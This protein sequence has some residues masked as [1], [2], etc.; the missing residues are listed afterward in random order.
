MQSFEVV[1]FV[2]EEASK[3]EEDDHVENDSGEKEGDKEDGGESP[4]GGGTENKRGGV[5][6]GDGHGA[7]ICIDGD[8]TYV[9]Y[10][11]TFRGN[12]AFEN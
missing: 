4:G 10:G 8:R 6:D 2:E 1:A 7:G 9:G 5:T 11:T 3:D 12:D